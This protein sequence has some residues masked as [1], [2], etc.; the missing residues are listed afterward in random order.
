MLVF[1]THYIN[2]QLRFWRQQHASHKSS[3]LRKGWNIDSDIKPSFQISPWGSFMYM[4]VLLPRIPLSKEYGISWRM[5]KKVFVLQIKP[6]RERYN[7]IL[8][9]LHPSWMQSFY[10][11]STLPEMIWSFFGLKGIILG[12]ILCKMM[13]LIDEEECKVL[14][15]R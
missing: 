1:S 12:S 8:R 10:I 2:Y 7:I 5:C 15:T 9:Q 6:P 13:T 3:P 4:M 11:C 14:H